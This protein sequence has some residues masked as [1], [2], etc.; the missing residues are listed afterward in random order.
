MLTFKELN[1]LGDRLSHRASG[2]IP[3]SQV[4]EI[5]S[6]LQSRCTQNQEV[7]VW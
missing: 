1:G 6:A 2:G 3:A 4:P 5:Q 7:V